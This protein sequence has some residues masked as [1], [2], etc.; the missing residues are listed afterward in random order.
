MTSVFD[1]PAPEIAHS[2]G[3]SERHVKSLM[4]SGPSAPSRSGASAVSASPASTHT[5]TTAVRSPVR[6]GALTLGCDRA[7]AGSHGGDR[8]AG[9][10]RRE[11]TEPAAATG[12]PVPPSTT[13]APG[14]GPRPELPA[15]PLRQRRED[16]DR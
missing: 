12:M 4:Y 5:S 8:P 13:G 10:A 11:P 16:R 7:T 15:K 2:L 1:H 3:V 14:T 6:A 9:P